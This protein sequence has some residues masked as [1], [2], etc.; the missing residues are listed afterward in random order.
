MIATSATDQANLMKVFDA[1]GTRTTG[2]NPVAVTCPSFTILSGASST[3]LTPFGC[4]DGALVIA[5][6]RMGAP[7]ST[8][9]VANF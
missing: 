8:L 6:S 7:I 4:K 9:P 3:A 1:V 5:T 2:G